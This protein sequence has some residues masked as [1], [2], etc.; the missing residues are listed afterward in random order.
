MNSIEVTAKI[1]AFIEEQD[2]ISIESDDQQLDL[3]SYTMMLVITYVREE[4]DI[5]LD[6]DSLDF[7]AFTSA[8]SLA[9]LVVS[10]SQSV[11]A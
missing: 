9:K 1:K 2:E 5:Q 7:D 8:A 3:D 11:A 4:M 10:Q 6:M